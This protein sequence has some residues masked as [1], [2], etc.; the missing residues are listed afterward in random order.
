[1]NYAL[2]NDNPFGSIAYGAI[3]HCVGFHLGEGGVS[4]DLNHPKRP[5]STTH[6]PE[7]TFSCF[8]LT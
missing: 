5:V 1:M 4:W 6:T 2:E 7:Q 3:I 8:V